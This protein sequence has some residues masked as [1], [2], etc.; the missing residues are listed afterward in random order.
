MRQT[1]RLRRLEDWAVVTR[2][3]PSGWQEEARRRGALRRARGVGG[4][5]ALLRTLL[6]HLADGCSL[7]ETA[8]RAKQAGWCTLSAVALFKRLQAAEHWLRWLAESLWQQRTRAVAWGRY[9]VRAI[10]ASAV[11]EAGRTGSL[12]RVHYAVGLRDLQCDFFAV[13]DLRGGET[14]RRIPVRRGD[15]ILGDRAY[16]TPPGVAHVVA[17]GGA[18]LVRVNLQSLPLF[19]E[20]GERIAAL[21]RVRTLRTGHIGEWSAYVHGP[22]GRRIAGR[23]IAVKRSRHATRA[24]RKRLR[25][26]ASKAQHAVSQTALEQARYF[27]VWTCVPVADLT[28]A[29]ILELYRLRW[30]IELAFKRLKSIMGLGQLPKRADASAR[31]WLHGKLF[32]ALLVERLI[33]TATAFSPWG[34][35]LDEAA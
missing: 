15:L 18:V 14:L 19:T 21:R 35:I 24:V 1:T 11:K 27:F 20:R 2:F 34:Y 23:L 33:E 30:Q 16:S 8:L 13:T 9:R 29:Q 5:E 17:A 31:A 4:A 6:V 32:V 12:W 7:Q 10:D 3:L 28:A 25:R 26:K 22:D